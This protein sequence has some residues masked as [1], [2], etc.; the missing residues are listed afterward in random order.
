MSL[1][2]RLPYPGLR[3]FTREESDLFFGREGCV[4]QMIDRLG[5]NRFLAVLGPSGSGK[6]S[7]VR[8]GLLDGLEL[9]LLSAA[10][11]HWMIA[12]L[13]PGGQ[14]IRK[15]AAALLQVKTGTAP[16]TTS[17]DLM[18]TFLRHGPRSVVEWAS[19][20]NIPAGYNLLILVDQFEELFRYADYAQREEAEAF[21]ATLLESSSAPGVPIYVVITMRSEYLGACASIHGLAERISAGL[22]LAPRMDRQECREAIEGPAGVVGFK[23]EPAL[24]NRMLND[25][26]SFA[27]W[28]AGEEG[29][30]ATQLARQADQLPL[31]Q[32]VLNRLWLRAEGEAS[33]GQVELKL[34][35]YEEIGGLS[36]ALDAHGAEVIAALGAERLTQ[37]EN[38]FRA[39]VSGNA[40]A[41]AVRRPC[42]MDELIDAAGGRRSDVVAIV[43]AFQAPGCN[44][45]RTTDPSLS[46]DAVIV[47]I[48]HESLIR[49][50][51]PLQQWLEKEARDGVVWRRLTSA[52]ERYAAREGGLLTGLDYQSSLAW[53]ET[54]NP[55]RA[56]AARQG[57]KYEA[58]QD[59]LTESRRAEDK[60]IAEEQEEH[61]QERNRLRRFVAGLATA[62]LLFV[63]LGIADFVA[64]RGLR[65]ARTDLDKKNQEAAKA[66]DAA[67]SQVRMTAKVLNDVSNTVHRY[68]GVVGAG[69]LESDL[70]K[71]LQPYE[72]EISQ[73]HASAV[74]EGNTARDDYRRGLAFETIG[75]AKQALTSYA[76]AYEESRKDI[77]GKISSKQPVLESLQVGFINAGC[78]YAWFLFDIGE[79]QEG[80]EVLEEMRNLVGHYNAEAASKELLIAHSK[81]ENLESRYATDHKQPDLEKQHAAAALNLAKRATALS[82]SKTDLSTASFTFITYRNRARLAEGAEKDKLMAQA[83]EL[84][85]RLM[86]EDPRN[87][88]S[89]NARYDC[90]L[91]QARAARRKGKY[92]EAAEKIGTAEETVE[93]GLRTDSRDLGLLLSMATLENF[94]ADLAWD[95][96][97]D[98]VRFAYAIEAKDYIVRALSG[99]TLFQSTTSEMKDLYDGCCKNLD[100]QDFP[101]P[102][103]ELKFYKD[104]AE[105]LAP[106]LEAFPKAPSFAYVAADA[107]ARMAKVVKSD[108]RRNKETEDHISRALEWFDKVGPL[109]NLSSY[110]EDFTAYCS[111]YN[112]RARLYAADG[113]VDL[114]L[115]DIKKMKELCTPALNKYPWDIYL[116]D[117]ILDNAEIA[118][119]GLFD[120]QRYKEALPYLEFASHWG[121][122]ESSRLLGRMYRD[123]LGVTWNEEKANEFEALAVGQLLTRFTPE[124]DFGGVKSAFNV[125]IRDWPPEYPYEGIDDQVIWLKEARNG[126]F[127]QP[128]IDYFHKL[129][130]LAHDNKMTLRGLAAYASSAELKNDLSTDVKTAPNEAAQPQYA[131]AQSLEQQKKYAE[132]ADAAEAALRLDPNSIDIM[133]F[134][135]S[136]YHDKLFRFDRAYE[137]NAR[138]VEMGFGGRDFVE[139]QLTTGRFEE[140]AAMATAVREGAT[141]KTT[142]IIVSSIGFACLTAEQKPEAAHAAGHRLRKEVQDLGYFNW[143]FAGTK[144]F[145]STNPAFAGKASQWVSLFEA[146]EHSDE[147]KVLAALTALG[148][149]E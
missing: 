41:T 89:I 23:V 107:S 142:R 56:W 53:W 83:C 82:G 2:K 8:T 117:Q 141:E 39:L 49:Q 60:R 37:I 147:K 121:K 79:D 135:E 127:T 46:N 93:G 85:D 101:S 108:A 81:L 43:D 29:D 139:K 44:F 138:R 137:L 33:G 131:L 6:S 75:D 64:I 128:T 133:D 26:G 106:T 47:D 102:A 71:T 15:L 132:A 118:G 32:H 96:H 125:Y 13:H 27:P 35:E 48:S 18:T 25:L 103:I 105:A 19:G 51:T 58:V 16:D 17:L 65:A 1:S 86:D 119:R 68:Q 120:S 10:S 36:G 92:D 11:S 4:D 3:A 148:V 77:S 20:G 63:A 99:R 72:Q 91:D 5:E 100:P 34:A 112:E 124:A 145:V 84:A 80:G 70:M 7:L 144:H 21:V 98:S 110:S 73:Q 57:G 97:K 114:M 12:D 40:L 22:Y 9:G 88:V 74:E 130:K 111:I 30:L 67:E 61:L 122:R 123:G 104:I 52:A 76:A 87:S 14:P 50:W 134:A 126:T 146:L 28:E 149:P 129:T 113:R 143:S 54:A 59:F 136:I 94:L 116:R 78:R 109:H 38:I 62:L 45:L 69:E 95:Q 31:M 66:R 24:V 55:T 140:C 115:R 90:L 42:R